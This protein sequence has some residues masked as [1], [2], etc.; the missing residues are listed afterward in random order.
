MA[1]Q[2]GP[3]AATDRSGGDLLMVTPLSLY[4]V[5]LVLL[6]LASIARWLGRTTGTEALADLWAA[7]AGA[8]VPLLAAVVLFA[9]LE[10]V[11]APDRWEQVAAGALLASPLG[12]TLALRRRGHRSL[13]RALAGSCLA[14]VVV[15]LWLT[16]N[17]RGPRGGW[18]L[19]DIALVLPAATLAVALGACTGWWSKRV[20][21]GVS[22]V[23]LPLLALAGCGGHGAPL[24]PQGTLELTLLAAAT[25]EPTSARAEILG[26]DEQ[27]FVPDGA[28]TVFSD[29][30][31]LPVHS[32]APGFSVVQAL[33]HGHRAIRNPYSGTTQFYAE[34]TIRVALPA[35][36]YSIRATKGMEYERAEDSVV[37]ES[38][39]VTR[40]DLRLRRW[41]DLAGEGWYSADD[42]L[43][44]PRPHPR[45]DPR[46]ATWME[47]EGLNVANLLEMGLARDVQI[48]PQS[49]LGHS[50][51]GPAAVYRRGGTL[52]L[53]GQ[54]NPRT[55]VLG[56]AIVLGARRFIDFPA[57]YLLYDRVWEEAHLQG[58]VNGYAHWGLAGAEEGL[59]VWGHE[60]L[61][62][63]V[64]VLNLGFPFY[65]RW[66]EALD[67]GLKI[68]P[69]AGTDYPCL[70][71]LPGRERFYARLDGPLDAQAWLEAVRRGS[72][73]VTNGPAIELSVGD[74]SPGEELRLAAPGAVRVRGRVRFD[75]DRDAISSLQLVQGGVVVA[76]VDAPTS[77]GEFRLETSLEID[78]TSWL[79]LR[80]SGV[81]RGETRIDLRSLF[82]SMLVLERGSNEELLSG[83]PE[84]AAPRPSAAHTAAVRVTVEGSLPLAEQPRGR[85]VARIWRARLDELERRLAD[86]RMETWARFPGRGDGID[87]PTALASRPAL[88][89]AIEA[90]RRYYGASSP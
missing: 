5:A 76:S 74:A 83:L 27:A 87:A 90:A 29:C 32:W 22:A 42:H 38:G 39:E 43:H 88:L 33:R 34:G 30:G 85:E 78:R 37:V 9:C 4:A 50:G 36:R 8:L 54:E 16:L 31:K 80:A 61:L 73:F 89:E 81:K 26:V 57:A 51:F 2:E 75:P 21:L 12:A 46:L 18:T 23:V 82:S 48:T 6:L 55:H 1:G 45:F 62:D 49:G 41:I 68:A 77:E 24:E 28:L 65:D 86:D 67:L 53:S 19:V 71:G 66:Y 72:T 14:V 44:I 58:A 10:G 15:V 56:H 20:A 79:A 63:F 3:A 25:G 69:T 64:E 7:S 70:P 60:E 59:A 13:P 47:A 35:G 11:P 17:L 40:S 84:G 52:I